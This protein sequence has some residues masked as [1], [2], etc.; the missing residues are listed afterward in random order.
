MHI[1][2]AGTGHFA[3]QGV[4]RFPRHQQ[5]GDA[6]AHQVVHAHG[7]VGGARIHVHHDTLTLPRD[8]RIAPSHVDG[9]VFVRT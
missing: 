9:H 7:R 5:H 8:R 3:V 2:V 6:R 1:V 4:G